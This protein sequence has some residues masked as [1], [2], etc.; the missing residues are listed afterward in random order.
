MFESKD[1]WV[2]YAKSYE[3]DSLLHHFV[4]NWTKFCKARGEENL[5]K[6]AE[7]EYIRACIV[8]GV[9]LCEDKKRWK[10]TDMTKHGEYILRRLLQDDDFPMV[11]KKSYELLYPFFEREKNQTDRNGWIIHE[12]DGTY[13]IAV[14][15]HHIS[16]LI[17][18]SGVETQEIGSIEN[19]KYVLAK[20][21]QV[22][23]QFQ[24]ESAFKELSEHHDAKIEIGLCTNA[25]LAHIIS[26]AA[27]IS[28]LILSKEKWLEGA[29]PDSGGGQ[30]IIDSLKTYLPPHGLIT[31]KIA[32]A[33]HG[34]EEKKREVFEFVAQDVCYA[35]SNYK[36][37][38]V[39]LCRELTELFRKSPEMIRYFIFRPKK[40]TYMPLFGSQKSQWNP[41]QQKEL[42]EYYQRGLS[43]ND[44]AASYM[45]FY[46]ILE[47]GMNQLKIE[48]FCN[49]VQN[50]IQPKLNDEQLASINAFLTNKESQ[51][52]V[53]KIYQENEIDSL[54][55]IV[56]RLDPVK[57]RDSIQYWL[58]KS[59]TEA[60]ETAETTKQKLISNLYEEFIQII[61]NENHLFIQQ[62]LNIDWNKNE[63]NKTFLDKVASRIYKVRCALTHSKDDNSSIR[64]SP[65]SPLHEK[66]LIFE[67]VLLRAVVNC[68]LEET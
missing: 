68:Y 48:R 27:W 31:L 1:D 6:M 52:W 43:T 64:Y 37:K 57:I 32:K 4:P 51:D 39:V 3:A 36:Q 19:K 60:T 18:F 59:T 7:F 63:A 38:S 49:T 33:I 47:Y 20:L 24:S 58:V 61:S 65:T 55:K 21:K 15:F 35:L 53:G 34:S 26:R 66:Y 25:F 9:Q 56:V 50:H 41:R 22:I 67:L 8:S 14:H 11:H 46:N 13:E 29:D 62:G 16:H 30:S 44:L 54:K 23:Q 17:Y 42:L 45:S 28:Q 2:Q 10:K 40:W 5:L 12:N